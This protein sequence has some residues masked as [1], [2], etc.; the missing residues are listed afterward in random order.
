MTML[1]DVGQDAWKS[2]EEEEAARKINARVQQF[3]LQAAIDEKIAGLSGFASQATGLGSPAPPAAAP[4][5]AASTPTGPPP[6]GD[7]FSGALTAARNAGADVQQFA[8]GLQQGAGDLTAQALTAARNAGADIQT[9]VAGLPPAP[10]PEPEPARTFSGV[11]GAGGGGGRGGFT[12]GEVNPNPSPDEVRSYITQAAQARGI[13][14]Q[15]ALRVAQGEGGLEAARRGTFETGSSWW[16]F[17]LHY[18]GPGYEQFGTTAGMGT[19]FTKKTGYQPGDPNA[20]QAATDFALDKAKQSGWG[21]WYGAK[22]AGI[23]GMT[24]IDASTPVLGGIGQAA[25]KVFTDISQFGDPQLTN[26]EAYAACGPAAAVRFAQRFGRNPTL[27]EA[28]DLA[29][30]V[31]WT[32]EQ[33]MAGI[34]SQ[35]RLMSKLGIETELVPGAQWERFAQEAQSGNPVTISTSA[36]YFYADGYNPAT[37][38]FHVGRSGTDLRGGKEWMTQ[39]EI[40]AAAER[41]GGGQVQ[42]ALLADNPTVAAPSTSGQ[43]DD[44]LGWL[45]RQRQGLEAELGAGGQRIASM[46]SDIQ[47]QGQQFLERGRAFA[48]EQTRALDAA[49]SGA[50]EAS[51]GAIGQGVQD[52]RQW[53]ERETGTGTPEQPSG[54]RLAGPLVGAERFDTGQEQ[55]LREAG[56]DPEEIYQARQRASRGYLATGQPGQLTADERAREQQANDIIRAAGGMDVGRVAASYVPGSEAGSQSE[57]FQAAQRHPDIVEREERARN[58]QT[59]AALPLSFAGVTSAPGIAA[60]IASVAIDPGNIMGAPFAAAGAVGRLG[61]TAAPRAGGVANIVEDV[62]RYTPGTPEAAVEQAMRISRDAP[63]AQGMLDNIAHVDLNTIPDAPFQPGLP[64]EAG[65]RIIKT[66]AGGLPHLDNLRQLADYNMGSRDW[67]TDAAALGE[68]LAPE[69][70]DEFFTINSITSMGT[71]LPLQYAEAINTMRVVRQAA[72][73]AAQRGEDVES[74]VVAAIRDPQRLSLQGPTGPNKR[75]AIEAAYTTGE[76]P[77][78]S[79]AKTSVFSGSHA[80]AGERLFEPRGVSDVWNWRAFNVSDD[81]VRRWNPKKNKEEIDRIWEARAANNDSAYRFVEATMNELAREKGL[82]IPQVQAPLWIGIKQMAEQAPEVYRKYQAGQFQEAIEEANR[83]GLFAAESSGDVAAVLRHPSV[84]RALD[85]A[86]DVLHT[87]PPLRGQGMMR[88]YAGKGPQALRRAYTPE[89]VAAERAVAEAAAPLAEL[90]DA[91]LLQAAGLDPTTGTLP[92]LT[93]PHRVETMGDKAYVHLP[94]GNSLTARYVGS[95]LADARGAEEFAVHTPNYRAPDIGGFSVLGTPEE[96]TAARAAFDE[97]G[98]GYIAG[99]TGRSVQI[100]LQEGF[101]SDLGLTII[102]AAERAGITRDR[103]NPYAGAT[104]RVLSTDYA[105]TIGELG[106]TFGPTTPGRSDL[107]QRALG[108]LRRAAAAFRAPGAAADSGLGIVARGAAPLRTAVGRGAIQGA[109][110]GGFEAAQEPGAGPEEIA[111][112][113][114]GGAALGGIRGAIGSRQAAGAARVASI[115]DQDGRLIP[116]PPLDELILPGYQPEGLVEILGPRGE[117]L[118]TVARKAGAFGRERAGAA[119]T[120]RG[121]EVA[122]EITPEVAARMPNLKYI[123]TD[124]PDIAATIAANA[125]LDPGLI[126]Q[127]KRGTIT[128]DKLISDLAKR[129]GLSKEEYLKTRPGQAF[130]EAEL[131]ALRATVVKAQDDAVQVARS[132]KEKGGV[133]ELNSADKLAAMNTILDAARIQAVGTGAAS[134]AGRALNQ[135]RIRVNREMARTIVSGVEARQA[136]EASVREAKRLDAAAAR[137]AALEA[138]QAERAL[139]KAERAELLQK[140]REQREATRL[141]E[142]ADR[143]VAREAARQERVEE[144]SIERAARAL[145]AIG[146]TKITDAVLEEFVKLTTSNDPVALGK[147]LR[148]IKQVSKWDRINLLR[149]AGMLSSVATHGTQAVSNALQVGTAVGTHAVAVPFDILAQRVGGGER[150]RYMSEIPDMLRGLR[151]GSKVGLE[152]AT[153]VMRSGVNVREVAQD[154]EQVR[155]GFGMEQTR[156]GQA[157]GRR[158]S[159]AVNVAA[160]GPL[161]AM[162]ASDLLFRGAAR[163]MHTRGLA[164]RKALAEGYTG[165]EAASRANEIMQNLDEHME[166]VDE[167]EKLSRRAVLQEESWVMRL[168]R[169]GAQGTALSIAL[170]FIRT[171]YNIAAQGAGLTPAGFASAIMAARRGERGEAA[172]RAGRALLGTGI[173]AVAGLAAAEGHLTAGYP[174]DDAERST[175]PPGWRPWSL[176]IRKSDGEDVYVPY[177][178]L[179]PVG[180]PMAMASVLGEA[181]RQNKPIDRMLPQAVASAGRF[182]ADQSMLQGFNNAMNALTDPERYGERF[183]ESVPTQFV[184][185]GALQRQIHSALG[186]GPRDPEGMWEALVAATNPTAVKPRLDALGNEVPPA[187]GGVGALISPM[188]YSTGRDSPTLEALRESEVNIPEGSKQRL[189]VPFTTE[190]QRLHQQRSGE[191]I[192]QFVA[193]FTA[194]DVYKNASPAERQAMLEAVVNAAR[195]AAAGDVF[196]GIS[197]PEIERRFFEEQRRQ[198]PTPA[199]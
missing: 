50:A 138:K 63:N 127:F 39:S 7:F 82:S 15:T 166:I 40:V 12:G 148:G 190:E 52:V 84:A 114:L 198:A 76:A 192:R 195:E 44:P 92:W 142:V 68:Q 61:R 141:K 153:E 64:I 121:A 169:T 161:R 139:S 132:I 197:Q 95:L 116:K 189:G 136:A 97:S 140:M 34:A 130:N 27:R 58:S 194:R 180:V 125:R 199:R 53:W 110:A 60:N 25:Q 87:P 120:A 38:Q 126:D 51:R 36:H 96:I 2:Y 30:T 65:G 83:M 170:P 77:V 54:G 103:L 28:T 88:T 66:N 3:G 175:L 196:K 157:I 72:A 134:T 71:R 31:G 55:L 178:A 171:P 133:K 14:P 86:G 1:P 41:L 167:A 105:R 109:V 75:K 149:Y 174:S 90:G 43:A 13:D 118:E 35:Q 100:P 155:G 137:V 184:P 46:V 5:P 57:I 98:V 70:L 165:A 119:V 99:P 67:Y 101:G 73:D 48:D 4:P 168:P 193:E 122:P 8:S 191:Y 62:A 49:V 20:W 156:L 79:G 16:P 78:S 113:A 94:G 22:A 128:H 80:S 42:G 143:R 117:L 56:I 145:K 185:Y 10:E 135:Q 147:F 111:Q 108:E 152:E 159:E 32:P 102:S 172:D 112:G 11:G 182:M 6:S 146:P 131:L 107:Q 162:Q 176:K 81:E 188:R 150:T 124:A 59:V 47:T 173:M 177:S 104:N 181:R 158:A 163:G 123:A 21:A 164:R 26:A 85:L 160:E 89:S 151:E 23:T 144:L 187:M 37:G 186:I 91:R 115:I 74:A 19:E 29:G 154:V 93:V 179:G 17:Q 183:I 69:N 129:F 106:S 9:F 45:D 33:G 18:G 24:G